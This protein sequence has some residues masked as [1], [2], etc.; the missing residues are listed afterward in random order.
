MLDHFAV[1]KGITNGKERKQTVQG[2]L[3][4]TNLWDVRK[5]RLGTYSGGMR[6]R[7]GIAQ[8]LLGE[9]KLIIVDEPTAGLDPEERRRFLN[10]LS[11]IGEDVVILLSTHIVDDVGEICSRMA[12]IDKGRVL[13]TGDPR[14]LSAELSG[15]IWQKI[16]EKHEVESY[17]K[18]MAVISTRLFA[19]RTVVRVH[20]E[21][22]P[23]NGF[24]LAGADLD[25]VYFFTLTKVRH[26]GGPLH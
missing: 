12:I 9:P 24:E 20:S 6:Q 5:Q 26:T 4:M 10:L 16:V 22:S 23:G 13:L 18:S 17:E 3:R 2:L 1:L 8:A 15:R 25:D 14:D 21:T 11:E 19:G 7:F